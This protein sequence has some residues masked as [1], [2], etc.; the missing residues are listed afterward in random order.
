MHK[1]PIIEKSSPAPNET[2]AK[3][4]KQGYE[5]FSKHVNETDSANM[6]TVGCLWNNKQKI[7]INM[8][9]DKNQ[10]C[11]QKKKNQSAFYWEQSEQN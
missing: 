10:A 9:I 2:K 1:W 6:R 4:K 8:S 3:A 7:H 11:K 5:W